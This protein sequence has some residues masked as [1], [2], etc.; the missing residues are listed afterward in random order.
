M[1]RFLFEAVHQS[2][3]SVM[4]LAEASSRTVLEKELKQR[5]PTAKFSW[6]AETEMNNPEIDSRGKEKFEGWLKELDTVVFAYG[7]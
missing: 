4:G 6:Y 3:R 2:G 7:D 1:S 5:F